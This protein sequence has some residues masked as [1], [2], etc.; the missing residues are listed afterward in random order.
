MWIDSAFVYLPW[1]ETIVYEP[2]NNRTINT[3]PF[4]DLNELHGRWFICLTSATQQNVVLPVCLLKRSSVLL[5]YPVTLLTLKL[6]NELSNF[7]LCR[8]QQQTSIVYR[9]ISVQR[10]NYSHWCHNEIKKCSSDTK[11]SVYLKAGYI[12]WRHLH[13]YEM[14]H[15]CI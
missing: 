6:L 3:N 5:T 2:W 9:K 12:L 14:L 4:P 13:H 7:T 8:L 10:A 15:N 11:W 1:V